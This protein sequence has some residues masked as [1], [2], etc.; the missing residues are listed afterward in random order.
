MVTK[1]I[2]FLLEGYANVHIL[3]DTVS[4]MAI[5]NADNFTSFYLLLII[6]ML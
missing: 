1:Y 5:E 3:Y 2:N 4:E 6:L